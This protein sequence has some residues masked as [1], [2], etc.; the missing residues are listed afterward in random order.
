MKKRIFAVIGIT[1]IAVMVF[2]ACS[3]G[4]GEEVANGVTDVS[5]TVSLS[6]ESTAEPVTE[7]TTESTT[8]ATT[9]AT[10]K[11]TTKAQITT[12][13]NTTAKQT[14]TKKVTTTQK[15]TTTKK[16]TTTAKATTTV[17][18]VTPQEVQAQVNSYIKSKGVK[19]DSSLTPSTAGWPVPTSALQK[20]LNDGTSLRNSKGDVDIII[21]EVG[22]QNTYMYCYYSSS[23]ECFYILY[24]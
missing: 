1:M 18:N 16:V 12:K 15:Q 20:Y 14:T 11:S 4:R 9:V 24:L 8:E 2:T 5:E 19:V 6:E 22:V 13:Q 10:T 7:G 3:A 17:K 21:S 23:E